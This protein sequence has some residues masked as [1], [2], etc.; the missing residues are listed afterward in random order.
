[1]TSSKMA[2]EILWK[3]AALQELKSVLSF[4]SMLFFLQIFRNMLMIISSIDP[5]LFISTDKL[6]W[7]W[8]VD[9][10]ISLQV[11]QVIYV[12]NSTESYNLKND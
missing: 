12:F 9:R 5:T 4:A 6:L 8:T 2:L 1:M 3:L 11:V 10:V 7:L